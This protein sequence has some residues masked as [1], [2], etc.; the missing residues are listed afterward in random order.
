MYRELCFCKGLLERNTESIK[1]VRELS[2]VNIALAAKSKRLE[3]LTKI[4]ESAADEST[5]AEI[6]DP[7]YIQVNSESAI[8]KLKESGITFEKQEKDGVIAVKI[9]R[10]DKDKVHQLLDN[11]KVSAKKL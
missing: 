4:L 10:N 7:Y 5:V 9:N 8:E 2:R 6:V 11:A 3:E 1:L